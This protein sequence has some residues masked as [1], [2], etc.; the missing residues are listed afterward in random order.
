MSQPIQ[1]E[2]C[3]E[4]GRGFAGG[5]VE[6]AAKFDI[7]GLNYCQQ[8]GWLSA[9]EMEHVAQARALIHP[10]FGAK[11]ATQLKLKGVPRA[12]AEKRFL[13]VWVVIRDTLTRPW[14]EMPEFGWRCGGCDQSGRPP[15]GGA[16]T[17]QVDWE[18]LVKKIEAAHPAVVRKPSGA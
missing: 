12:L 8:Q 6:L 17:D 2:P 14:C 1:G 7:A 13:Q 9:L 4:C 18:E 16:G 10:Q 3:C 11:T 15:M 5:P